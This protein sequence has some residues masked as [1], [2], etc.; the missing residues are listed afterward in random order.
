MHAYLAAAAAH[1]NTGSWSQKWHC[2]WN[3]PPGAGVTSAGFTVGHGILPWLI[4][5]V[6]LFLVLKAVKGRSAAR[7][8]SPSPRAARR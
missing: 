6:V 1:C 8:P 7:S 3:Q 4:A 5:A 2:G